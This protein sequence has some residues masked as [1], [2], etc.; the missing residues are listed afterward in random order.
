LREDCGLIAPNMIANVIQKWKNLLD[1]DEY[2]SLFSRFQKTF[3]YLDVGYTGQNTVYPAF[4][5]GLFH[6]DDI[7]TIPILKI[8]DNVLLEHCMKISAYDFNTELDVNILG[9]I[10]EHSLNE[11]EEISAELKGETIDKSKTKRKKDGV[12][13]TPKYVTNY[14]VENTIGKLCL[15]NKRIAN[16]RSFEINEKFDKKG[17]ITK[18][19]KELFTKLQEYKKWLLFKN[20]RP[21][22]R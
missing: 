21:R 7:L 22:L 13:Y 5:G 3:Q 19:G 4:N 9:H 10:F 6:T 12:F 20:F 14:I 18:Q 1:D 15:K 11:I 16:C 2:F 17:K 8:D